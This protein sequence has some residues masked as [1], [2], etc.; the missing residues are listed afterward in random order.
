MANRLE[1]MDVANARKRNFYFK[2]CTYIES[3]IMSSMLWIYCWKH[4]MHHRLS[5]SFNCL[6]VSRF[7]TFLGILS[8]TQEVRNIREMELSRRIRDNSFTQSKSIKNVK[9]H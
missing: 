1:E 3:G 5:S 2:V 6:A 9:C 4:E 7:F 8:I